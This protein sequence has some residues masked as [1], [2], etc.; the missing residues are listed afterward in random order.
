MALKLE[1]GNYKGVLEVTQDIAN[2]QKI[3]GEKRLLDW[4]N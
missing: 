4:E 3:S 2:I 1:Q